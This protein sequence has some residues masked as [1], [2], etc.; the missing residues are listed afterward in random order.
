MTD[1][2]YWLFSGIEAIFKKINSY[3]LEF[4]GYT[5]GIFDIFISFIC[6]AMILSLF[7][8]GGRG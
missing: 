7:W 5:L 2:I 8:K 1:S 3:G 4:F 6:L